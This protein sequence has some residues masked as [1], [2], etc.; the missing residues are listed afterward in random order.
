MHAAWLYRLR[1]IRRHLAVL[2]VAFGWLLIQSQVAIASHDCALPSLQESRV[3]QHMNHMMM[4]EKAPQTAEMKTPLCAKHCVP[5]M[6]QKEG[7]H[8]PLVALP[9]SATLAVA[10]PVCAPLS[11]ERWSLTP[12]AAGPPA[13]IRFCRFRE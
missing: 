5:D 4:A 3:V 7:D 6:A 9:V 8:Q 13:T 10:K 11:R 2:L 12:P 1:F